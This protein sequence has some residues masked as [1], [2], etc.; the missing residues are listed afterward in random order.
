MMEISFR[1]LY[2]LLNVIVCYLLLM[3]KSSIFKSF[4]QQIPRVHY[5]NFHAY[6][7]A[8]RYLK[9]YSSFRSE[10]EG[11]LR[12]HPY[13]NNLIVRRYVVDFYHVDW[14]FV[15]IAYP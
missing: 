1:I 13:N 5:E 10:R 14:A 6:L 4:P 11:S 2:L 3:Q 15:V 8:L 12:D 9:V 7:V